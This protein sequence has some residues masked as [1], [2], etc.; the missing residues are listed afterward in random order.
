VYY[1]NKVILVWPYMNIWISEFDDSKP[2]RM[3]EGHYMRGIKL[4][5]SRM[6]RKLL[7]PFFICNTDEFGG[8]LKASHSVSLTQLTECA[9]YALYDS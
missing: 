8:D 7:I 2:D 6:V 5:P 1:G 9:Y 4:V 3:N